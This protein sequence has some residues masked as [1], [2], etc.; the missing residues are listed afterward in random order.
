MYRPGLV[1][2]P[3]DPW[4]RDPGTLLDQMADDSCSLMTR[5]SVRVASTAQ[6][7]YLHGGTGIAYIFDLMQLCTQDRSGNVTARFTFSSRADGS[8]PSASE[9]PN[10]PL[11]SSFQLRAWASKVRRSLP[12]KGGLSLKRM[13]VP[14]SISSILLFF[15]EPMPCR[16]ARISERRLSGDQ[17]PRTGEVAPDCPGGDWGIPPRRVDVALVCRGQQF[18]LSGPCLLSGIVATVTRGSLTGPSLSPHIYQPLPRLAQRRPVTT[19]DRLRCRQSP[20][21]YHRS[22]P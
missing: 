3:G 18:C 20:V 1:W 6:S 14:L 10:Y 22:A 12:L 9:D 2:T 16:D 19:P 13:R 21:G 4:S 8:N 17:S 15:L 7:Y 5:I 11:Y